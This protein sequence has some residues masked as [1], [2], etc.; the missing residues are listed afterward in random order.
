M[1]STAILTDNSATIVAEE[2]DKVRWGIAIAGAIAAIATTLFLLT[3]GAGVGLALVSP[4]HARNATTYV[5]LGA[6]YFL[7]SQAFGFAVGGY[8][9]GRLIGPEAENTAEEEFRAGAHG[10]L[11]WALAVVAGLL[12]LAASSGAAGSAIGAALATR[13]QDAVSP[14]GYW[15]DSMFRPAPNAPQV[16]ADK[17]EA[18][19]I[20]MTSPAGQVSD[21]DTLRLARLVSE[22][23]GISMSAA[24]NRVTDAEARYSQS[25]NNARKATAI[26]ALWTAFSLLF[27]AIVAV[28][29]AIA[30]RWQD[31]RISFSLRP[32]R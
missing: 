5:T 10:F 28:A 14:V 29:A 13:P 26:A 3:L 21:D 24:M 25:V 9:V 16:A 11:M 20:L 1:T 27:G 32:R 15:V 17:A 2:E 6:I 12:L 4:A 23:S 19:R 7:A 31:D 30:A 22:D 8:L 18:S